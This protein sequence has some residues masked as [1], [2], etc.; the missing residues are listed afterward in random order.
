MTTREDANVGEFPT[1][2]LNFQILL[3]FETVMEL[4]PE[5]YERLKKT[6]SGIFRV[7]SNSSAEP[8]ESLLDAVP[9]AIK[10]GDAS[11]EICHPEEWHAFIFLLCT[12][13]YL[14]ILLPMERFK[15]IGSLSEHK[16]DESKIIEGSLNA[17]DSYL[18]SGVMNWPKEIPEIID[19]QEPKGSIWHR[20][21]TLY[22][23]ATL[24]I[25]LHETSHVLNGDFEGYSEKSSEE[26]KD[27]EHRC[28][29]QAAGWLL[30]RYKDELHGTC[31]L[32]IV[33]ALG[34]IV[35][36]TRNAPSTSH[37]EP[38]RRAQEVFSSIGIDIT[39][40]DLLVQTLICGWTLRVAGINACVVKALFDS[41]HDLETV[42]DN[43]VEMIHF[44]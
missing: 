36:Y 18:K 12:A 23:Q 8:Y 1:K 30:A 11:P 43:V 38:I 10:A 24:L 13:V 22:I 2:G 25:M 15:T 21:K 4:A 29:I 7:T 28:D 6:Y 41:G 44:L 33:I 17:I 32:S 3:Q 34:A 35:M 31:K 14:D 37:P 9:H 40:T 26:K 5:E 19:E 16:D 20:I 39:A 27:I 42:Y